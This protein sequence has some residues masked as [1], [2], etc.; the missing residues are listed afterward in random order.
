M[1]EHEFV[2]S[3]IGY[4][5]DYEGT[6]IY[7][8]R[9]PH[10]ENK[11]HVMTLQNSGSRSSLRLENQMYSGMRNANVCEMQLDQGSRAGLRVRYMDKQ[12]ITQVK[13]SD[14]VSYRPCTKQGFKTKDLG[15][16]YFAIAAKNSLSETKEMQIIDLDIDS[17]KVRSLTPDEM[18]SPEEAADEKNFLL[19]KRHAKYDEENGESLFYITRLFE[20]SLAHDLAAE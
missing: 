1:F 5:T 12:V 20:L 8:F 13:D 15:P 3:H 11:W 16:H 10:R 4:R 7:V 6:A 19:L 17:M 2:D 14:D 18:Y 9:H